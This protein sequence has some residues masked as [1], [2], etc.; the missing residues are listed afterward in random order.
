MSPNYNIER[1]ELWLL[2]DSDKASGRLP[3]TVIPTIRRLN[4]SNE[5]EIRARLDTLHSK[6]QLKCEYVGE[7]VAD[8][9]FWI[10]VNTKTLP[11]EGQNLSQPQWINDAQPWTAFYPSHGFHVGCAMACLQLPNNALAHAVGVGPDGKY[12]LDP[13]LV[14]D[15]EALENTMH[16]T[17]GYLEYGL[18]HLPQPLPRPRAPCEFGYVERFEQGEDALQAAIRSRNAFARY[19]AY[20]AFLTSF[21]RFPMF[22]NENLPLLK[23]LGTRNPTLRD[24]FQ[25]LLDDSSIGNFGQGSRAGIKVRLFSISCWLPFLHIW[26]E[27]GVPLWIFIGHRPKEMLLEFKIPQPGGDRLETAAAAWYPGDLILDG[28]RGRVLQNMMQVVPPP[29]Q[30]CSIDIILPRIDSFNHPDRD[31][32]PHMHPKTFFD[33]Q[34]QDAENWR[35]Y[36]LLNKQGRKHVESLGQIK[37]W[38]PRLG[39][40]EMFVWADEGS[41]WNRH[42]VS[43][44]NKKY[45]WNSH[46]SSQRFFSPSRSQWD[47][48]WCLDSSVGRVETSFIPDCVKDLREN[49]VL[50]NII[51]D[52][53][54][55]PSPEH[56]TD[57]SGGDEPI[58]DD[59]PQ[60]LQSLAPRRYAI[61]PDSESDYGDS[62]QES[63]AELAVV[64][65]HERMLEGREVEEDMELEDGEIR[66]STR[67]SM[68][69]KRAEIDPDDFSDYGD[70]ELENP[71]PLSPTA[72]KKASRQAPQANSKMFWE[73]HLS[74]RLGY[75]R[76]IPDL[77]MDRNDG[78]IHLITPNPRG[79][80]KSLHFLGNKRANLDSAHDAVAAIQD[81][82]CITPSETAKVKL[83]PLLTD[84]NPRWD[85]FPRGNSLSV[86][87][88][89]I[90]I[91]PVISFDAANDRFTKFM[92][93]SAKH[94]PLDKQYWVLV[95]SA[96]TVLHVVRRQWKGVLAIT[97]N[98]IKTGIPFNTAVHKPLG[99]EP[100]RRRIGRL[101]LAELSKASP[102]TWRDYQNYQSRR[103]R[104]L[105]SPRGSLA[106]QAGGFLW[107]IAIEN[108]KPKSALQAPSRYVGKEGGIVGR[109]D[110]HV[111]VDDHLNEYEIDAILG[112]YVFWEAK[113]QGRHGTKLVYLWPPIN[114][115]VKS[116]LNTGCWNED[117][118]DFFTSRL[119]DFSRGQFE[120]FTKE[121]WIS[122]LRFEK[123]V[124]PVYRT[125]DLLAQQ[126]ILSS[127]SS[128]SSSSRR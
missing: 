110:Q 81:L 114:A 49:A 18:D 128:S 84:L 39:T 111:L 85:I 78:K 33:S 121:Q 96:S 3:K 29:I 35:K 51:P 113:P 60:S 2:P 44:V 17:I 117:A 74:L 28:T 82:L 42:P 30:S 88:P 32:K 123:R 46:A 116:G 63:D 6:G 100:S 57:H 76:D 61:D 26:A 86:S 45:M 47:L 7:K 12:G 16:K 38:E 97:T 53:P 70:D 119:T 41:S 22:A 120:L 19:G 89:N 80:N 56:Y 31:Y 77:V 107:R 99:C 95:V 23:Y 92:L 20:I 1:E 127:L 48:C 8:E 106:L 62:E 66:S 109:T 103:D 104:V 102:F 83:T 55:S 122:K 37:D 71:T 73:Q 27:A 98:L 108:V 64:E 68:A 75:C 125:Y 40:V 59:P 69:Q 10:L 13:A 67:P 105:S 5:S 24:K 21:W 34:R 54:R 94:G 115:W 9:G 91:K 25:L 52:T 58:I 112:T 90:V 79:I 15:W 4:I 87:I 93:G 11:P 124:K 50:P 14:D 36:G 126:A 118:E 101:V 72:K 43:F 65:M